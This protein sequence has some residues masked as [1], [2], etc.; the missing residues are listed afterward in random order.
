MLVYTLRMV[1]KSPKI[2]QFAGKNRKSAIPSLS[3]CTAP[4]AGTVATDQ[5]TLFMLFSIK[6][7]LI[8]YL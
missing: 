3:L 7:K 8:I 4:A 6:E 2:K 1:E 5:Y